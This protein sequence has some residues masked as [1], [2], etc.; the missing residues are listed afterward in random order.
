MNHRYLELFTI[1]IKESHSIFH[2][3]NFNN[4]PE[5]TTVYSSHSVRLQMGVSIE[6]WRAR[7]GAFAPI[8]SNISSKPRRIWPQKRR[9]RVYKKR[10]DESPTHHSSIAIIV[11]FI[12][13]LIGIAF[14]KRQL[15]RFDADI[16]LSI[17]GIFAAN[18]TA[19][20]EVMCLGVFFQ[21]QTW[22]TWQE[23]MTMAL[24]LLLLLVL[25]LCGDVE[26]NPGPGH[27]PDTVSSTN[28]PNTLNTHDMCTLHVDTH[29]HTHTHLCIAVYQWTYCFSGL[30]LSTEKVTT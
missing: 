25:L 13:L 6:I 15:D 11:C 10:K 18:E 3:L 4:C 30:G 19:V 7:I 17:N 21:E 8:M 22:K 2:V 24:C 27:V 12:F 29:T 5:T 23:K 16:Q 28:S 9:H 20:M 14:V 1:E 26:S